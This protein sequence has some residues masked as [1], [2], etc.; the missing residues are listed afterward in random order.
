MRPTAAGGGWPISSSVTVARTTWLRRSDRRTHPARAADL[1]AVLRQGQIRAGQRWQERLR[2]ELQSCR[3]VLAL[4][5]RNWLGSPWCFAEAVTA[6]FRGKDVVGIET[7]DL[8]AEDLG[9]APPILHERQRVRLR[10]GDDR[11]WQEI[12]EALDRS[13]LDPNDWF[14]IPP[15]VGPYP[16][17]VAF[18]EKDAGVFFGRKQEITEYLGILD[19]LRGPDRSQLLVISG[20]SGSGKSSLLRAGLIPRLRRKPEWVV[21]SPFEVAREPVRNL[22]DRL[23]EAQASLGIPQ[24]G[25]DLGKPPAT[26]RR[27]PKSWMR[28]CGGWSRR[29][30]P[31]CF[32]R[33]IRRK[34]W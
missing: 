22:L 5:S 24:P 34:S 7:E 6:T 27:S 8:T 31:G 13:G 1:V 18:D 33:L 25:L 26:R 12:L 16:G 17:L 14:P 30:A 23:G 2:E 10:D 29:P 21:I 19:T 4:L 9:R 15:N 20:A 3:V 32:C 11:P 28:R